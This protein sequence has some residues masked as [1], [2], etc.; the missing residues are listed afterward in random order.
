MVSLGAFISQEVLRCFTET[1][2]PKMIMKMTV[3]CVFWF[4]ALR[5]VLS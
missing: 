3:Y 2:H 1:R 5:T 4:Q